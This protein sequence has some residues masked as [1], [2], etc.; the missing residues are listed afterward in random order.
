SSLVSFEAADRPNYFLHAERSGY[1]RLRKWENNR[2]FC[3]AA[4]FILHRDTW[5]TGFDSLESFKW[6]GFFLHYILYKLQ[7]LKYNHSSH[8]RR[9]TLFKLAGS[10][11][12]DSII[13]QCQWRYESCTSPCFRTCSDPAAQSCVTTLKVE[14][15][16]PQCP[17]HMVMD[18]MTQRC[19]Y[20]EDCNMAPV[21]LPELN[22]TPTA[23][24]SSTLATVTLFKPPYSVVVD[25]CTKLIC[26]NSQLVLFNK[27]QSCPYDSS[28][29]NCGLLGFAV[30][31]NGDKCCPKWNCPC[32]CSVFP[33]INVVTFDGNSVA[34]YKAAAYV[35]TQLM[36]ETIT[37]FVQECHSSDSTL[38]WNFTHLCLAVLNITHD[39]NQVLINRLQRQ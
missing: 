29:P 34:L 5:I 20:L 38:V 2:E 25:E 26:V 18:E 17:A 27:S 32:R 13:P 22:V 39:S 8:Y 23:V 24:T 30:L 16:L 14:G 1:L 33:D 9:A 11:T 21:K 36:N 19:V 12:G 15:C 4:T 35:V 7:L 37:I 3:D 31:V 10:S 28:P 6:P